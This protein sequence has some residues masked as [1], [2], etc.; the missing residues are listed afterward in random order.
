MGWSTNDIAS[1]LII[2]SGDPARFHRVNEQVQALPPK[3][4][5]AVYE[6]LADTTPNP[7]GDR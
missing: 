5:Q 2:A 3:D 7:T 1:E 6:R 4:R